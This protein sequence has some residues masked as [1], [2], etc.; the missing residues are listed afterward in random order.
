MVNI[1]L[2]V[3]VEVVGKVIVLQPM[4]VS[5]VAQSDYTNPVPEA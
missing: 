4:V 2:N 1:G 5:A 3:P